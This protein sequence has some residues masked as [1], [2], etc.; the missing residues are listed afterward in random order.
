MVMFRYILGTL[1]LLA[2]TAIYL[3]WRPEALLQGAF[4]LPAGSLE[5]PELSGWVKYSLTDGLWYA[6]LLCFEPPLKPGNIK[7]ITIMACAAGP[8]HELLQ[9]AHIAPGTFCMMD[10]STYLVILF[11]YLTLC[12]SNPFQKLKKAFRIS[13][14]RLSSQ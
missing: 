1:L 11:L 14:S 12:I 6:S 5:A 10:L 3:V 8:V 13:P 9:W 4:G 7:I 2:G